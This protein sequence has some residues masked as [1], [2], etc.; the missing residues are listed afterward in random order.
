MPMSR[1]S[2][3]ELPPSS[4]IVTTAVRLLVCALRPRSRAARPLPPPIATMRGP[5][6]SWPAARISLAVSGVVRWKTQARRA[7]TDEQQTA[8]D[9]AVEGEQQR[10]PVPVREPAQAEAA[11]ELRRP[12]DADREEGE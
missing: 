7:P 6:A 3:P 4:A 9:E 8:G 5:R 1:R 11:H 10:R 2:R 12:R